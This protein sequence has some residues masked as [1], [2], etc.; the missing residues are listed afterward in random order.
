MGYSKPPDVGMREWAEDLKQQFYAGQLPDLLPPEWAENVRKQQQEATAAVRQETANRRAELEKARQE[1]LAAERQAR[2]QAMLEL[3]L[4]LAEQRGQLQAWS[5]ERFDGPFASMAD[6]AAEVM[7]LL[8]AGMLDIDT[9]LQTIIE[10]NTRGVQAALD[11]TGTLAEENQKK[12]D[13][14]VERDYGAVLAS[15]MSPEEAQIAW[16]GG[17]HQMFM[18]IEDD[19]PETLF[20]PLFQNFGSVSG[21][22]IAAASV[23]NLNLQDTFGEI[24]LG[25]NNT[26]WKMAGDMLLGSEDMKKNWME[27]VVK[28]IEEKTPK[29][30]VV[31]V[32]TEIEGG[33]EGKQHGGPVTAGTPYVV[34]EAGPELFVPDRAGT[35]IPN[36]WAMNL[37]ALL[38]AVGGGGGAAG[39][40]AIQITMNPTINTP[41]D[42]A[43][44]EMMTERTVQRAIRGY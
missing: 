7:A 14:L 36:N 9:A 10:S 32:Q 5:Q 4:N 6:S 19:V 43:E 24:D 2:N 37:P 38:G 3:V 23:M 39:S 22:I 18:D 17:M 41:M 44:F 20:D 31:T 16:Y 15:N 40:P 13:R 33:T 27:N 8:D 25:W 34:G 1:E 12:L 28:T 35:V 29:K 11:T 30:I 21:D 42:L 26:V